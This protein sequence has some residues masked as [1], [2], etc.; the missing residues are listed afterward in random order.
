MCEHQLFLLLTR[1]QTLL[2]QTK[3][4]GCASGGLYAETNTLGG[5]Y[6]APSCVN[7]AS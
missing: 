2:L 3:T 1:I 6:Y 7:S 5:S 4:A